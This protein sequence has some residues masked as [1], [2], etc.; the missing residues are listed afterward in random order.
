MLLPSLFLDLLSGDGLT[1]RRGLATPVCAA[2]MAALASG[3]VRL[4]FND[5]PWKAL[6]VLACTEAAITAALLL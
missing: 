3:G 6:P 1:P 2:A 5:P 4:R